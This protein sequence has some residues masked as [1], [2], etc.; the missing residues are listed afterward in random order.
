M[1]QATVRLLLLFWLPA[2]S[3]TAQVS[4]SL[5]VYR[6][7]RQA[8]DTLT[9]PSFHGRGYVNGGDQRAAAYLAEQFRTMGLLSFSKNYFQQFKIRVNT[10]PRN[11]QVAL[12]GKTLVPGVDYIVHEASGNG[13]GSYSLAHSTSADP[14]Q[15]NKSDPHV[16]VRPA[17]ERNKPIVN[18]DKLPLVFIEN[19]KLTADFSQESWTVPAV[20]LLNSPKLDSSSSISFDIEH[21]LLKKYSTQNVIGYI[22]GSEFP[23]SFLVFSAHYDHL[24]QMGSATY[25]PGANDNASGTA[26]LL[27]LAHY[28]SQPEHRPRYSIA[29]MAF[30]AEEVGL[31]GSKFYTE[32]PYFPLKNIRFLL[33][34]DIFGTGDEGITAVNGSVFP[35]EFAALKKI[36]EEQHFL[37][38]VKIR[39]KAANSDHYFFTEKG[40]PAFF[41]YTMGGIKAYH[42]VFDRSETLPLSKFVDLYHL[43]LNFADYLQHPLKP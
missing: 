35:T 8:V 39:G 23:D 37:P 21:Q 19:K 18:P 4:D 34:L 33:N 3:L 11:M 13:K 16:Q 27:S 42:D 32:H 22:K 40:V 6:F 5:P 31:L 12:D 14:I 26:M 30:S 1:K 17:S 10:F 25:F 43:I 29:F 28:F 38:D 20:I 24:G 41:I 7:A 9:S 2:I 15:G 36:N